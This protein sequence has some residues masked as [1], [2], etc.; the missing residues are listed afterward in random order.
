MRYLKFL[1][2]VHEALQPPTYLEVGI[3]QGDSLALSRARTVGIDP[4]FAIKKELDCDVALFRT[5]SDE[6][7][8]RPDP[9]APLD[10]RRV[11]LSFIDGMHLFEYV[12]RDFINVERHADWTTAIVFDDILPRSIE[13]AARDRQTKAWTG[14]VYKIAAVLERERPD[15]VC[16]R[17]DTQPTGLLVVLGADPTSDVL[18]A[19]CDELIAEC[20]TPDPQPVPPAVIEREGALDPQAVLAA[21]FWSLLREARAAG[22]GRAEGMAALRGS[23]EQSFGRPR[24]RWL[25]QVAGALRGGR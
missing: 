16:L 15:L 4:A 23:L 22:T 7:F 14:D 9:L 1:R 20:V 5:T 21:P 18:A 10:G 17:V 12:L 3:R 13:E 8:A 24:R 6:Y 19:R 2:G 25:R 11:A